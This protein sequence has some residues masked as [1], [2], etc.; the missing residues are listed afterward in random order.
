MSLA[1]LHL[2]VGGDEIDG[3]QVV[4]GE[5]VF[6][7]QPAEAPAQG[8]ARDA[9]IGGGAP[10]GGEAE[11]LGLAVEL[12]PRDPTLRAHRAPDRIDP[13]ALHQGQV[14]H[15][16]AV[17]DAGASEAVGATAHGHQQVVVT[18]E[19][20]GVEDVGHPDGA[21]DQARPPVDI[22]VPD[23]AGLGIAAHRWER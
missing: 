9:G 13:D 2:A 18:G 3:E 15:Q 10:G 6:V 12:A 14:D 23:L 21:G 5:P 4:R 11:R 16:P 1:I 19:V 7:P 17:A 8:Q 20:D 22:G